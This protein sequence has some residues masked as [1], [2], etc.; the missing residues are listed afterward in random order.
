MKRAQ[1]DI[2]SDRNDVFTP[3]NSTRF[4]VL[5]NAIN[6]FCSLTHSNPDLYYKGVQK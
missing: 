6:H 1:K 3:M 5:T 2:N 4:L